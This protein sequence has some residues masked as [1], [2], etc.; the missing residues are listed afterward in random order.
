MRAPLPMFND[1]LTPQEQRLLDFLLRCP[2][3]DTV[4]IA[5]ACSIGNVSGVATRLNRALAAAGDRRR[6][7]CEPRPRINQFGE[8]I[9]LGHWR[10][11]TEGERAAA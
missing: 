7:R 6:V 5:R 10:L 1:P 8:R 11:V 4:A 9:R 2:V 3:A